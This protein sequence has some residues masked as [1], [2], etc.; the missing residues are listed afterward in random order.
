MCCF[1]ALADL[2]TKTMYTNRTGAFP[3]RS[4]C[5]MQ[6]MFVA[7]I[8]DLNAILVRAMP[9]K[10]NC[11][12]I[13]TFMDI[14]ANLNARRYSPILNVMDNECSKAIKAHIRSNH[15]DI[16][17]VPPHNHRVDAAKCAIVTFKEHL[18]SALT[19]V[20]KNC[21]LQLWDD[22]LPQEEPTL[23]LLRFSQQDPTKSANKKVNRKFGYNKIPLAT[24]GT[25]GLV[26]ND[27]VTRASWTPHS[28]NA[29]YVG[30]ELKHYLCPRFYMPGT[31]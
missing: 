15:I 2:H 28:T 13:A 6:Y 21:L 8:Y 26:Y 29:Y 17:L 19:T 1:V 14:L 30:S 18:T 31:R 27:P 3:V 12:M 9:S 25:K 20:N 5:N 11:A 22:F 10:T 4:F 7:Y 16:H 23:N 24:L